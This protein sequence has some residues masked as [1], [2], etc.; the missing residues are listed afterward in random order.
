[1]VSASGVLYSLLENWKPIYEFPKP[2]PHKQ[3][4]QPGSWKAASDQGQLST[5]E[6]Q[7]LGLTRQTR[8]AT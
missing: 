4:I 2:H 7:C 5:G 3:G 1:M 6:Q 8:A